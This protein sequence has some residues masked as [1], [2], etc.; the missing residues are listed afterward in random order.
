MTYSGAEG[1]VCDVEWFY[2]TK[3]KNRETLMGSVHACIIL[4]VAIPMLLPVWL[5]RCGASAMV[6]LQD[7]S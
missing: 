1:S 2:Y 5:R 6:G 4:V 3:C 7:V